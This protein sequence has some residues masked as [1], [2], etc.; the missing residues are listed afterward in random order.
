MK[1]LILVAAFV[2]S[3]LGLADAGVQNPSVK[4]KADLFNAVAKFYSSTNKLEFWNYEENGQR[5][6]HGNAMKDT[7]KDLTF[8]IDN[9]DECVFDVMAIETHA[10]QRALWIHRLDFH[11][12]PGSEAFTLDAKNRM[13]VSYHADLPKGAD[14]LVD[15]NQKLMHCFEETMS[16]EDIPDGNGEFRLQ[17][18]LQALDFLKSRCGRKK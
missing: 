10:G 1:K 14:C 2:L 9:N 13:K 12:Y 17:Q 5:F 8:V 15:V 4:T 11:V 7:V 6:T 16:Y 18:R 3:S